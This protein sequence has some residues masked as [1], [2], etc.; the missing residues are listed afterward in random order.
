[1]KICV[2]GYSGSG[3]STLAGKLGERYRTDVLYLDRVHWLPNWTMRTREEKTRIV[4]EFLDTHDEWVIDG[5]YSKQWFDR[6]ME[7]ADQILILNFNRFRCLGR[8]IKRYKTYQGNTRPDM[9]EG[10]QEKLDWEF[11]R[12]VLWD[13]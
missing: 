8:V 10:C 6:R 7:E 2:I 9:G 5:N 4:G 3:K 13:G 1:M 12:W 11:I